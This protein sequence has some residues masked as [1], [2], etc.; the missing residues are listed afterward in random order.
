[1]T[2]FAALPE[3]YVSP[4]AGQG[5]R[6]DAARLAAWDLTAEQTAELALMMD[7]G[8]FPLRGYLSQAD[9]QAVLADGRLASGMVWPLPLAL[10]VPDGLAAELEPGQDIALREPGG[11]VLAIMSVTDIWGAGPAL[12]GGRIK[13]LAA[14]RGRD[15]ALTPNA[16]RAR[17]R[18]AGCRQVLAELGAGG[19]ML[20]P[21][22]GEPVALPLAVESALGQAILARNHGATH[23]LLPEDAA[24]R[25]LLCAHADGLGLDPVG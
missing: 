9:H 4:A 20:R 13:G 5:L 23:L 6:A 17:F 3:L 15:A 21:D 10:A 19:V 12:L 18:A 8:L 1:M 24:A 16:L 14:P 25:R 11:A 7:G 2:A 22:R